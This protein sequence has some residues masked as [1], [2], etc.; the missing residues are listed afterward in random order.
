MVWVHGGSFVA[1]ATSDFTI[2]GTQLAKD[3]VVL[4]SI[5]YRLG[6]FGF[7]AHPELTQE[8]GAGSGAY[9]LE[10]QIAALHW[11]QANIARF[12]GDPSRVTLFGQSAGGISVSLLA[13]SPKTKGLFHRV[14][15]ESSLGTFLPPRSSDEL[16]A[17]DRPYSLQYAERLGQS[18][19]HRLGAQNIAAARQLPTEA[20]LAAD[21]DHL[22]RFWVVLD[23]D[24]LRESNYEAYR[25]GHFNDV[26]VLM[27]LNSDEEAASAPSDITPGRYR[28]FARIRP[29]SG[30]AAQALDAYPHAT[31]ATATR[32]VRDALRDM[33]YGWNAWIWAQ[34]QSAEGRSKVFVYYFDVRA[35]QTPEGAVHFAE[36]PYVFGNFR[37]SPTPHDR[38]VSDLMRSYWGRFAEAGDPNAVGRPLWPAFTRDAPRAMAFAAATGAET[39]PALQKMPAFDAYAACLRQRVKYD[40]SRRVLNAVIAWLL[41]AAVLAGICYLLV[42]RRFR[43]HLRAIEPRPSGRRR[44]LPILL[45]RDYARIGDGSLVTLGDWAL[46]AGGA[47]YLSLLLLLSAAVLRMA[48]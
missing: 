4:V 15:A 14:I 11:V 13:T 9:G 46:T 39:F 41:A 33:N 23:G 32:A 28:V 20:F 17:D 21:A 31:N 45:T 26:P 2:D 3:G 19:L 29:C 40:G 7:L 6:P 25:A 27:G 42:Q 8:S 48:L 18:F 36:V 30:P 12:G 16:P 43:E 10:D 35:P 47:F 24:V 34:L 37:G 1:G 44:L 5:A 22:R 38:E